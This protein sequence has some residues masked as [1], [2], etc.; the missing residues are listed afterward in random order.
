[1][2]RF[3]LPS[4]LLLATLILGWIIYPA[5]SANPN[6]PVA[7]ISLTEPVPS[8][9]LVELFT[10]EGC[11]SCPPADRVLAQLTEEARQREQP[12]Y[13]LSFH[14]DYWNYLGWNDPYSDAAY[15]ERQRT[16]ART[17]HQRTYTPQM[18]V[19]GKHVFVGS[20]EARAR[21]T[22]SDV[23]RQ[24]ATAVVTIAPK[25]ADSRTLDVAYTTANAPPDAV[26]H[27]AVVERGLSQQVS[28]GENAGRKLLHEHVVRTFQT[29]A[30]SDAHVTLTLPGDLDLR[31]AALIAFVQ[32]PTTM[33]IFGA[34][35]QDLVADS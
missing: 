33:Q 1:M 34:A 20:D 22:L 17:L 15:S 32:H 4:L 2:R 16:Y 24:P 28:R 11:S 26:V 3:A 18:V 12:I 19:N 31:Q 30:S 7:T 8:F 21:G 27:F 29:R 5:S 9:A 23:L 35:M 10:S 25:L 14:V 6:P 13:T